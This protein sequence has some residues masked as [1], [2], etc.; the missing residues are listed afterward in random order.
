MRPPTFLEE[1]LQAW[2]Y[3]DLILYLVRRDITT[4]YK[5]SVLGVAWTMLNPLGMMIILSI[6]FSH[7]FHVNVRGYPAY[8]L[9]GLVVW[10]FF[11]Q[12]STA[13]I[14][15]LVWGGDLF[16]R[17]YVP[18]SAFAFSSIGTGVVNLSLS[19]VPLLLVMATLGIWPKTT[20]IFVP[21]AML[22]LSLFT[23]GVGLLISTVGMYFVD[24]VEMYA[25]VLM[26]WMYLT[27]VIYPMSALPSNIQFWLLFNPMVHIVNVF[28]M[29]VFDGIHPSLGTWLAAGLSSLGTF[30]VGWLIFTAKVDEFAYRT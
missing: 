2:R 27:P 12:V 6:V 28:R 17:I 15:S 8:V 14:N 26:G 4:R 21:V 24:V 16:R 23:M 22:F 19:L 11:A 3:R 9:S 29:L 25:I 7:I 18:R 10:N 5:R 1:F 13:I 30:L 20:L